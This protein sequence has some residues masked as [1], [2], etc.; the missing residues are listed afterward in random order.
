MKFEFKILNWNIAGGKFL[1]ENL[2]DREK[3]RKNLNSTLKQLLEEE[4]PNIVTLQE[5]VLYGNVNAKGKIEKKS[6]LDHIKGY[7]YLP[8]SL[9]DTE[10]LS[11]RAKWNKI[12]KTGGWEPGTYF[13]QGNGFLLKNDIYHHPIWALPKEGADKSHIPKK[14]GI[15]HYIE[16][17]GLESGLNF[18]DRDTEPRVA[19]VAHFVYNPGNKIQDIFVINVHLST[20]TKER[21]GIPEIDKKAT[22]IRLS[23]LEIIFDGIIS[24]YNSWR[25]WG[26]RERGEPREPDFW[27]SFNREE[28]VWIIAG[29][30]NSTRE[31]LEYR[32]IHD[33][34][35]MDM[36]P[37]TGWGTGTKASGAGKDASLTLDYIF[38]GPKFVSLDPGVTG[39]NTL[40]GVLSQ[41]RVSDHKPILATVEIWR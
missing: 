20:L 13:A 10:N 6:I 37:T 16:K 33:M 38:A 27:E 9:I 41:I 25:R 24:R 3:F 18:G 39:S 34:N 1:E 21:E 8:F 22:K 5:I 40:N 26:F 19:L 15:N 31:S 14:N 28:P 11:I 17:V 36:I 30:F 35:F 7:T 2:N 29:D 32:L 23:Q 4:T 12:E